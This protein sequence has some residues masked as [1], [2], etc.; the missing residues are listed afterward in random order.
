MRGNSGVAK[1]TGGWKASLSRTLNANKCDFVLHAKERNCLY[2]MFAQIRALGFRIED[3]CQIKGRHTIALLDDWQKRNLP[4]IT[5]YNNLTLLRRFSVVIGKAGM[6]GP[7]LFVVKPICPYCGAFA[8]L[9]TG[10]T[11][12]P[13]RPDLS[14]KSFWACLPECK[15]WVGCHAGTNIPYG[16]L[17]KSQLRIARNNVHLVFDQIWKGKVERDRCSKSAARDA[18]YLWLAQE[19]CLNVENCHIGMFD[20][21]MCQKAV[22]I[23]TALTMPK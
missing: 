18:T 10:V 11:V 3:V 1:T 21:E 7:S 6:I 19:L 9:V 13:R 2:S 4:P 12:Y 8:Q 22:Q 14:S 16:S 23:C 17:A 5:I 15:A 20:L